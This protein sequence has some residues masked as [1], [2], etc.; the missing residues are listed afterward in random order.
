[1]L[2]PKYF[3]MALLCHTPEGQYKAMGFW[4]QHTDTNQSDDLTKYV[5]S[6]HELEQNTG[7]DFFCN[8]PDDIERQVENV[9]KQQIISNWQL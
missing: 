8:L 4:V 1:M 3:F 7:I 5:V 6:I 9:T 2:V